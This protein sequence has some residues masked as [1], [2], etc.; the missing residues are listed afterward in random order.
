MSTV[1][2]E[3]SHNDKLIK[4]EKATII[5]NYTRRLKGVR[6]NEVETRVKS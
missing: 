6:A 3:K 2:I 5:T 4:T 1:R